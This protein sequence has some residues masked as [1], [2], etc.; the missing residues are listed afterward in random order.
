MHDQLDQ[1]DQ[2]KKGNLVKLVKLVKA[3]FC[4]E[5]MKIWKFG[6][7]IVS[8]RFCDEQATKYY[9]PPGSLKG[10]REMDIPFILSMLKNGYKVSIMSKIAFITDLKYSLFIIH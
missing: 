5:T 3:F 2:L 4:Y 1:V 7:S 6:K 8:R 10:E 9:K